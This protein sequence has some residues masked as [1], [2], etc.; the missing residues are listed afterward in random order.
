MLAGSSSDQV[1]ALIEEQPRGGTFGFLG[2]P[3]V[4]VLLLNLALERL[5]SRS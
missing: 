3:R 4:N 1:L 5:A 2:E